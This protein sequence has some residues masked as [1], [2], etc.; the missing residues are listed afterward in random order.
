MQF[1]VRDLMVQ[2]LPKAAKSPKSATKTKPKPNPCTPAPTLC[3]GIST[4]PGGGVSDCGTAKTWS[5]PPKRASDSSTDLAL[6]KQSL[7]EIIAA[8]SQ[9]ALSRRRNTP[10]IT[11]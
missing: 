6:L 1:I 9:T 3:A 5:R 10:N 7:R 11:G 2:A 4:C 8:S